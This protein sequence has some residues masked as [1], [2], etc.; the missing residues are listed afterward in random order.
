MTCVVLPLPAGGGGDSPVLTASLRGGVCKPLTHSVL[1]RVVKREHPPAPWPW[2]PGASQRAGLRGNPRSRQGQVHL[3]SLPSGRLYSAVAAA[4]PVKLGSRREGA[5]RGRGAQGGPSPQGWLSVSHRPACCTAPASVPFLR[6]GS[7]AHWSHPFPRRPA[8]QRQG[9]SLFHSSPGH[10]G[11]S[12]HGLDWSQQ[13][14]WPAHMSEGAW[15]GPVSGRAAY[16][17]ATAGIA[18][19]RSCR[20]ATAANVQT[21]LSG[22]CGG[23]KT[24]LCI[25]YTVC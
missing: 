11:A 19:G 15:T 6:S 21:H 17:P 25:R 16:G 7:A 2:G 24:L 22:E 13:A 10:G 18:R 8:S 5:A 20:K 4:S 23:Q 9:L 12:F 1:R 14:V 3:L